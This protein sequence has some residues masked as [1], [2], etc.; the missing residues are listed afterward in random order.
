[1]SALVA[2]YYLDEKKTGEGSFS[3]SSAMNGCLGGLVSITGS[4]GVVDP[5]AAVVTGFFAGLLYISTSKLLIRLRIDD[6]VDAIPVHMSNGIWGTL[7]VGLFA[8]TKRLEMAYGESNDEGILMGGNGT[9]LACQ[10]MGILFVLGWV[11]AVMIPFFYL[12]NYLGWLRATS[13]DE[14]EGLDFRYH[15][16]QRRPS[17]DLVRAM[18]VYGQG[19]QRLRQNIDSHNEDQIQVQNS[20]NQGS[21]GYRDGVVVSIDSSFEEQQRRATSGE[22]QRSNSFDEHTSYARRQEYEQRFSADAGGGS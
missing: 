4:C 9:L 21:D 19:N 13:A 11:T 15:K 22:T 12:L 8:S 17:A 16:K 10:V 5:W 18:T 7:S 14:V 20:S 1:M 6:A 3:L 2:Q